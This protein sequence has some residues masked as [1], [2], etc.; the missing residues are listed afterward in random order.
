MRN[1]Q[2]EYGD[3]ENK[4]QRQDGIIDNQNVE[5][6]ASQVR[7]SVSLTSDDLREF[8]KPCSAKECGEALVGF[9]TE[10]LELIKKY[11]IGG[12]VAAI[13]KAAYDNMDGDPEDVGLCV[14]SLA[15]G[16]QR[17]RLKLSHSLCNAHYS[18]MYEAT[19][20]DIEKDELISAIQRR[21]EGDSESDGDAEETNIAIAQALR[22]AADKIE[23]EGASGF[24]VDD[25]DS[26]IDGEA[27]GGFGI[28]D[29]ESD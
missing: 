1:K 20:A 10:M 22:D 12:V 5:D 6:W 18:S 29:P 14:A 26:E 25:L 17:V 24:F 7:E 2:E 19:L 3:Q 15:S 23:A 13:G 11:R 9:Q 28:F 16:S 21:I 27:S 8:D 4:S